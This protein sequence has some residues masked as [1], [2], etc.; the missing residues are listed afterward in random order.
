MNRLK[1]E[2]SQRIESDFPKTGLSKKSFDA[3]RH[4]KVVNAHV[5]EILN[6]IDC[7]E[8]VGRSSLVHPVSVI[9]T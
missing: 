8:K 6:Q 1:R 5:D 9:R 3:N 2:I 7:N 4:H